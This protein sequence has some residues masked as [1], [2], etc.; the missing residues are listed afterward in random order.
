MLWLKVTTIGGTVLKVAASGKLRTT[1]LK[2]NDLK[3]EQGLV[4]YL[5]RAQQT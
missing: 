4:S 5:Q 3:Q 2:G 1:V